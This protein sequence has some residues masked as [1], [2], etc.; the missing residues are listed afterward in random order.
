VV[1]GVPGPAFDLPFDP[2][3]VTGD[4]DPFSKKPLSFV[5][6]ENGVA[7]G[8]GLA[9]ATDGSNLDADQIAAF[10]LNSGSLYWKYQDPLRHNLSLI[11]AT[12]GNGLAAKSTDQNG[13]DTVLLFDSSG[14]PGMAMRKVLR[15]AAKSMPQNQ[16]ALS[17]FSN[18]DY[19]SNGWWVGNSGGSPVVLAGMIVQSAMSSFPH[20]MGSNFAQ[21]SHPPSIVNFETVD[22]T[23][24]VGSAA[25]FEAR[26]K[27]TNNAKGLSIGKLTE[28]VFH[29]YGDASESNFVGQIFKPIDA[30]A[31]IGHSLQNQVTGGAIGLCFGQA[32]VE[33]QSGLPLYPCDSIG[34][35]GYGFAYNGAF[36]QV[37]T[38]APSIAS[39]AKIIFFASCDLDT[40]MQTFLGVANSTAGRALL[41][42]QSI[43]D[44]DL[45]M[46]EFEW[47]QIVANLTS[48]QNLQQA[49]A[50][51][52]TAT[53]Q[54]TWYND[55]GQQVPAQAW[56]VI[57]DSG[58]HGAGIHF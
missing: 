24:I 58:N 21:S 48:G 9:A 2:H 19:Y 43:T 54:K 17:G 7:F 45:D 29:I 37:S 27:A 38:V 35:G 33:Q 1:G 31:F 46:G 15:A 12:L 8:K 41:F 49:V 14:T 3:S 52:N 40:A 50:N 53:A 39:Q 13:I 42:P 32:G 26:Y 28:P 55:K 36:Y 56:Q 23:T 30:I 47:E 44:I 16:T 34:Q 5:L 22:P 57:G 51:A 18:V 4:N 6:G 25:G 10:D 11:E 20:L